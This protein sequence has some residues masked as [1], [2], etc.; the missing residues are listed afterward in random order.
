VDDCSGARGTRCDHLVLGLCHSNLLVGVWVHCVLLWG[1]PWHCVHH[2]LLTRHWL[3]LLLGWRR[4]MLQVRCGRARVLQH[5]L[6][7]LAMLLLD[8]HWLCLRRALL[9]LLLRRRLLL[10]LLHVDSLLLRLARL[11]LWWGLLLHVCGTWRRLRGVHNNL[12]LRCTWLLA[13]RGPLDVVHLRWGDP[14][15]LR[16]RALH[17]VH[18]RCACSIRRRAL[19]IH[20]TRRGR[21]WGRTSNDSTWRRPWQR[22]TLLHA[23]VTATT[24]LCRV[25]AGAAAPLTAW[26]PHGWGA[27]RGAHVQ[28]RRRVLAVCGWRCAWWRRVAVDQLPTCHVAAHSHQHHVCRQQHRIAGPA[29]LQYLLNAGRRQS[30]LGN[31]GV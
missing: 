21:A 4:S 2:C 26:W 20:H 19:R 23:W 18:L 30:K 9:L 14:R 29:H 7:R 12:R 11:R 10:L 24:W 13:W 25:P 3:L 31:L 15:L 8:S 1:L 17:I 28:L 27:R 5:L 22:H 6:H 16:R